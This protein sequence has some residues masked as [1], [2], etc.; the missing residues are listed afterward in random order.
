MRK[1]PPLTVLSLWLLVSLAG[2]WCE[3][4]CLA[5]AKGEGSG[6]VQRAAKDPVDHRGRPLYKPGELLVTFAPGASEADMTALHGRA[7]A[8]VVG[9]TRKSRLQR[10][11]FSDSSTALV[12][13]Q[14]YRAA[15]TVVHVE[16]NALRYPQAEPNDTL[17]GQQWTL[18]RIAAPA[19]WEFASGSP[20]VV[21]AVIDSGV[22]CQHPDLAANI[23]V[24][25]AERDGI[26]GF[27]DDA[28]GYVDDVTG[29]DFAGASGTQTDPDADPS[30][31]S[32]SGHGTHVA[33]IIAA[34][35]NNAQGVAGL[36]WSARLMVLKVKADDSEY[37]DTYDIIQALDYARENGARIVNCSFGGPDR[38]D[39]EQDAFQRLQ[40]AG[41]I[42]VCAA[43]NSGLDLDG[44]QPLYPA[45]Y[46][47]ANIIAVAAATQTDTLAAFSN[48]GPH[49][50][51]LMAPGEQI[52]ST[53]PGDSYA[54]A[55]VI[56]PDAV[57]PAIGL[58]YAGTTGAA[59]IPGELAVCG[60]GYP[61]EFPSGLQDYVA[62]IWRSD[63]AAN[64][65][66]SRKVANAQAAGA[67]AVVIAN[68]RVDDLDQNGGTLG[69]AGSWP[70]AVSVTRTVGQAL[71]TLAGQTV[72]VVNR[73]ETTS[74]AYAYSQGTSMAAP[75]VS[76][77]AGLIWSRDGSMAD[78]RV[79]AAILE[80]VDR[81]EGLGDKLAAGGRVNAQ[82]ALCIAARVN[83]DLNCDGR[84]GLEDAI[85]AGQLIAGQ[86][87]FAC[88]ACL[89][90]GT[91]PVPDG[92]VSQADAVAVL[93]HLAGLR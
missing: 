92:I 4:N 61:D 57:H 35:G 7:G 43:G 8:T 53:V 38:S 40:D 29:W 12:A 13:M 87:P 47:L 74:E 51:D 70:P 32:A 67:A 14:R 81:L 68:N 18:E 93:Q 84:T 88:R 44:G 48:W 85:S 36:C 39:L 15:S 77:L 33:G 34:V 25:Q 59:G 16:R 28:N 89:A 80:G 17:F 22:A 30:D 73:L 11:R 66:F 46:D 42:T 52:Y 31:S 62:L 60:E 3:A 26:A 49:S 72:T 1:R 82:K 86:H 20:E 37:Y 21:I 71:A 83:G 78:H 58:L 24:N 55:R 41:I 91:D 63:E 23:W 90:A 65:L 10:L 2:P 54:E 5:G 76:A 75:H 45:S 9:R 50:V 64:F 27:D 79:K 6:S 56:A 19:A 69:T